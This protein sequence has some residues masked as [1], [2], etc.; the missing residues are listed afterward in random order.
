MQTAKKLRVIFSH[1]EDLTVTQQFRFW[2]LSRN[3]QGMIYFFIVKKR[4]NKH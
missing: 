3:K 1:V 4:E 2:T